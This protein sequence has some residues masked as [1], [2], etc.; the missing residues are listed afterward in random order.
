MKKKVLFII[1]TF[2]HG[3]T[4]KS[5]ENLL[6]LLDQNKF[7]FYIYCFAKEGE[8]RK[9]FSQ[10]KIVPTS[11]WHVLLYQIRFV[12][13]I[14]GKLNVLMGFRISLLFHKRVAKLLEARYSFDTIVAFEESHPTHFGAA[15]SKARKLVWCQCDYSYHYQNHSRCPFK[16]EQKAY[17]SY[18]KIINVSACTAARMKT[19]LPDIAEKISFVYNTLNIELV[20]KQSLAF[21]TK[22]DDSYFNIVSVGRYSWIKRFDSIPSIIRHIKE[23]NPGVK[24]RWY[25][26]GSG[27]GIN[28]R[29]D[30]YE[31]I[32]SENVKDEV[33]LL[34]SQNNPYPFIANSNLLVCL[35]IAESWS[36]VIN[37]AKLLHVPVVTTDFEAAFEVVNKE[38]GIICEFDKLSSAILKL[39]EDENGCYSVLK[40]SCEQYEY[41]NNAIINQVEK[42]LG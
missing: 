29:N 33:I 16:L 38:T 32:V 34:G 10:Y 13:G 1:P 9:I 4:N 39:I 23:L 18:D 20:R 17:A 15:F 14:L 35:S 36:Y 27:G 25:I 3:G 37:E 7:E 42:L 19:Y 31:A 40:R 21:D 30:V 5:L 22:F 28:N 12:R 8:Y 6:S 26:I 11:L 2:S 41:S 24:I